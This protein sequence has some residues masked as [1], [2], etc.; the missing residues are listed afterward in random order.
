MAV[1]ARGVPRPIGRERAVR[2]PGGRRRYGR[3]PAE[4]RRASVRSAG[5][6]ASGAAMKEERPCVSPALA[7]WLKTHM[8]HLRKS[9]A[10]LSALPWCACVL[11]T[12]R[13]FTLYRSKGFPNINLRSCS[14]SAQPVTRSASIETS[15]RR[16]PPQNSSRACSTASTRSVTAWSVWAARISMRRSCPNRARDGSQTS[17]TP[18]E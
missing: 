14:E 5:G 16:S 2:R 9:R 18:S 15:S 6:R 12:V 10:E 7:L 11:G 8:A 4:A 17:G 3:V 13:C 1:R